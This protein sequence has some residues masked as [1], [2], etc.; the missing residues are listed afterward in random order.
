MC[1]ANKFFDS[2]H[3]IFNN[4]LLHKF[5]SRIVYPKFLIL[6]IFPQTQRKKHLFLVENY[7]ESFVVYLKKKY[8]KLGFTSKFKPAFFYKAEVFIFKHSNLKYY[9]FVGLTL[10]TYIKKNIYLHL[11]LLKNSI[12]KIQI[13]F[14]YKSIRGGFLGFSNKISGFLPLKF[15]TIG[16]NNIRFYKNYFILISSLLTSFFNTHYARF[17]IFNS[18]FIRN[19]RKVK[20]HLRRFFFKRFKFIFCFKNFFFKKYATY[21]LKSFSAFKTHNSLF[22][23]FSIFFKLFFL[24]SSL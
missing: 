5:F 24:L 15:F 19:F 7:Y 3:Y 22:V 18:G 8:K 20:P 1:H 21:F 17:F 13:L 4:F 11:N 12:N 9:N 2:F 14:I 10:K 23:Y 16:K 6:K